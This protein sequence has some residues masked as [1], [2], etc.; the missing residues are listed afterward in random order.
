MFVLMVSSR[1]FRVQLHLLLTRNHDEIAYV[2]PTRICLLNAATISRLIFSI[3]TR[4]TLPAQESLTVRR[5][6]QH[7][8]RQYAGGTLVPL[9]FIAD[10]SL[11][12]VDVILF[13]TVP[14]ERRIQ[15][16]LR[17]INYWSSPLLSTLV[18]STIDRCPTFSI[19]SVGG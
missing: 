8:V 19:H 12:Y 13:I 16:C 4:N 17:P 10:R 15:F 14:Q 18:S 11:R 3:L 7:I 1:L 5:C 6:K 2:R 9:D